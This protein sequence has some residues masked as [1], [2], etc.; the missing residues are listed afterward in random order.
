MDFRKMRRFK[1]KLSP[2]ECAEVLLKERRGVLCVNGEGG[3]PYGLPINY[4]YDQGSGK[5]YFHCAKEGHK[6]D[7]MK[8]DSKVCF[9][10]CEQGEQR[11][12][13]SYYARS[14]IVFGR[15]CLVDDMF[16]AISLVRRLA[17][18]YY[19]EDAADEIEEDIGR[20]SPRMQM[21]KITPDHISGKLVHEK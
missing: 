15:A 1:Q 7:A 5:I 20:N 2:D 4:F 21:V 14:V 9:T 11:E 17:Q 6:L 10:V 12:D 19:P 8:A 18:K 16:E 13:W 3:Y